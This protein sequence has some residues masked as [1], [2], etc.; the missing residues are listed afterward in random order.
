MAGYKET[1]RQKMI[2]MMY[3]VL[4]AL[5]ALN[6]SVEV[7]D[8]FVVVNETI[9]STNKNFHKK[10]EGTYHRFEQQHELNPERVGPHF[11]KAM[12]VRNLSNDLIRY[13]DSVKYAAIA[14]SERITEEEARGITLREAQTKDKRERTTAF[15]I[16]DSHDGS[17]GE[18][19]RLR[20]RV[21]EFR[22]GVLGVLDPVDR[23]RIKLGLDTQG[24]FFDKGGAERNWEMYNFYNTILAANVTILNKLINEVQN[25]EFDIVNHL[26]A[27][28]DAE[29]F[30]FDR[31]EA[32]VIPTSNYVF[33]GDKFEAEILVAAY[34]SKINPEVFI[35]DGAESV[36]D[37]NLRNARPIT[38]QEGIARVSFPAVSEGIKRFAGVIRITN[39][40]GETV[41]YPFSHQYIVAPPSLTVSATRMN[42]F[43]VGVD[44]PVSIS[45]GGIADLQIQPTIS[46]G[47]IRRD[48]NQWIVRVPDAPRAVITVEAAGRVMGTSEYRVKRVPDPMAMIA[49]VSGGPIDR[50]RLLAAPAIIPSMPADFEFDLSF[51]ITSFSFVATRAGDIIEFQGR[52]NRLT[53]EMRT[54]IQ[55]ARRGDRI[56]LENIS[57]VGPDG[58]RRLGSINLNIM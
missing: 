19:Y 36:N 10:I 7:L 30:R 1:P 53:D 37:Q 31:V 56:W 50:N 5:L 3:L 52:G 35:V 25:A 55:N 57:A 11:E 34:D 38:G 51:E 41:S 48:G 27:A 39:P 15:F 4:T 23:D 24:P 26:F 16:G 12:Y 43:Y 22:E 6:V 28:I 21:D 44:N 13:I 2:A 14:F 49:G 17:G 40:M 58:S 46:V 18:S 33:L 20:R 9:E 29:S 45:V 47:T 42:V 32:R 54:V 8:A